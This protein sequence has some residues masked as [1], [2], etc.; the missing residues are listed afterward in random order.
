VRR[1]GE[2]SS[3]PRTKKEEKPCIIFLKINSRTRTHA[4]K[5]QGK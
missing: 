5:V 1:V 2:G 4:S 3:P